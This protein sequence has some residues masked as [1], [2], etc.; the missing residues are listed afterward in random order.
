MKH[1]DGKLAATG[2]LKLVICIYDFGF[3]GKIPVFRFD[4]FDHFV[5]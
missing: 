5:M 3:F 1:I 2:F 4:V